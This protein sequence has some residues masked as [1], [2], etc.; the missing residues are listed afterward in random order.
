MRGLRDFKVPNF[1]F[2]KFKIKELSE[3][4][5]VKVDYD[6]IK[7]TQEPCLRYELVLASFFIV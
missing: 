2:P 5:E 3:I 4:D 6:E 1:K 7:K